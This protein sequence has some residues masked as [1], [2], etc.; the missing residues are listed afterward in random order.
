MIANQNNHTP[1]K[2]VEAD[3]EIKDELKNIKD[4]NIATTAINHT[5]APQNHLTIPNTEHVHAQNAMN[6]INHDLVHPKIA[7]F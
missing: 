1:P 2:E 7:H 5:K 4:E 6:F 3:K